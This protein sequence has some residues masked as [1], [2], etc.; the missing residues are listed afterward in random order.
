MRARVIQLALALVLMAL[1]AADWPQWRGLNRDAKVTGFKAPAAWPGELKKQWEVTVGDGVATPAL[2]DNKLYVFTRE[3]ADEV[4]RSLDA[5]TGKELWKDAYAAR[6]ADGPASG[7]SGPRASPAVAEG[8]V[9]TLGA[10]G[11]LSCYAAATGKKLWSK[12]DFQAWPSFYTSASPLIVDGLCIAQLGGD[13]GAIVAY[14]LATGARKWAASNLPTSYSS[15]VLM[16][17]AGTKLVIGQVSDGIVAIQAADGKLVWEK[18]FDR[19]GSRYK[20]ATPIVDGDVVVYLDGPAK[21]VRLEKQGDKF[22]DKDVWSNMD[23]RVEYNTPLLKDGLLFG[24]SQRNE[25]FCVRSSDGATAWKSEPMS[26]APA[27]SGGG[28]GK[29]K[30]KGGFGC[31]GGRDGYGSVVDA[32]TVL[33][34]LTPGAQLVVF[35]P[36]DKEFKQLASFKISDRRT[37]AAYPI[38]DGNRVFVKDDTS[39]A[40][41]ILE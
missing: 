11:M 9:V 1:A 26:A 8:R 29:G 31:G 36:T 15:P 17:V 7:F 24:L 2:V 21:A 37:F 6:G 14:D 18:Y 13:N 40:L 30:F 34:G 28:K 38:V 23:S 22:V 20:A 41:W 3:G 10:R 35:Q 32:G 27:G 4:V 19:G 16:T 33:L 12:D 25:F 39:V 5:A